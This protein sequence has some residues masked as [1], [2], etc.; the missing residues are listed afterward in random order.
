MIRLVESLGLVPVAEGIETE[1]Q[2][3]FLR[4]HG[5]SFGQGYLLSRPVEASEIPPLF[6]GGT[7]DAARSIGN[8]HGLARRR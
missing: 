5:C 8:G 7:G 4:E 3:R 1:Q 6:V 2:L